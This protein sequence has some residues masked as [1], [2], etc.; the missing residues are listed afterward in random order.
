MLVAVSIVND[1]LELFLCDLK[2]KTNIAIAKND[3]RSVHSIPNTN[4]MSFISKENKR[5]WLVKSINPE[6]KE[7]KNITSVGLSEDVTWLPNGVLLISQGNS[8]YKFNPKRNKEPTVFFSFTDK[9]INNISRIAVNSDGT[10][11]ALV[12]EVSK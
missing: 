9:N 8:I 11:L 3:G 1:S 7:I 2:K 6:T 4:L 12:A 10:K 5:S